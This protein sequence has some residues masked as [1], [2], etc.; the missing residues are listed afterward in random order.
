MRTIIFLTAF[1]GIFS[2]HPLAAQSNQPVVIDEDIQLLELADS[3]FIHISWHQDHRFGRFPSNGMLLV[4]NGEALMIDTPVDQAKTER[5]VRY[6]H[7]SLSVRVTTLII[8]HF[9]DD[10]MGGLPYLQSLGVVSIAS[11]LTVNHCLKTGRPVP[12]RAFSESLEFDFNGETVDCRFWGAGHSFDNITVYFPQRQI[13]FG[14]CL[15]KSLASKSPGNLSDAVIHQWESTI[16]RLIQ[17]YP[18][19]KL[20]I[21]GHGNFGDTTLLTHTIYLVREYQGLP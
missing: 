9:H 19:M 16:R 6:L 1:L 3:I 10:C 4:R 17:G 2:Q 8:G 18:D 5:L 14:G 11:D 15:V 12:S 20:V 21:P 7:D 13:L